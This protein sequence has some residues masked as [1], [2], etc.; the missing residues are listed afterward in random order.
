MAVISVKV[1][2]KYQITIPQVVR[3]KLNIKKGDRLLMD[4]QDGVIV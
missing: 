1:S 2:V 4:V 3:Q